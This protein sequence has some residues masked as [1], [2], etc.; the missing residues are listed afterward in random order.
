MKLDNTYY[1]KLYAGILGKIIGVYAGRPF[2]GWVNEHIVDQFGEINRYVNEQVNHPLIVSDDDITGTFMFTHALEDHEYR[3]D[4]SSQHLGQS[5]LDN[6]IEG[7][8]ILWWGGY[9]QSTEHTAWLNLRNGFEAPHSGSIE[10]NGK[11]VA[12]Q[13]GAQIF[14]DG[15]ALINPAMPDKAAQMA[16]EAAKVSHDGE[17]VHAAV[18]LAVMESQAFIETD[19]HALIDLGLS[20]I[21]KE[22][23]IAEVINA[24]RGWHEENPRDW[25][26]AFSQLKTHYG[27][28]KF[29]GTCHVIPNH[30]LIILSLLYGGESFHESMK[31]VNTLGWD[32]DCNAAN[33]GCL[34]GI[35][36]GLAALDDGFDWRTPVADRI[37]LPSANIQDHIFDAVQEA[38]KLY[39]IAHQLHHNER[40]PK[41]PR[42]HFTPKGSLQGFAIN[43][44][45][46]YNQNA[47]LSN[48]E[49]ALRLD[50]SHLVC[51]VPLQV[52]TATHTPL[53]SKVNESSYHI[54]GSP[55]LYPSQTIEASVSGATDYDHASVSFYVDAYDSQM[56]VERIFSEPF[57]LST[58]PQTHQWTL[59]KLDNVMIATVGLQISN[60]HS[61]NDAG[62]IKLHSLDWQ[63][64]PSQTIGIDSNPIHEIWESS[65]INTM[66]TCIKFDN[67]DIYRL[68]NND[69]SHPG[70][71]VY[72]SK[73]WHDYSLSIALK[74]QIK[75]AFG[76]IVRY[77]GL[78]RYYRV[79]LN[80][81]DQISLIR[82]EFGKDV[83][84]AIEPFQWQ[85]HERYH[86]DLSVN[87]NLFACSINGKQ[88][89]T[90]I[91]ETMPDTY[92][93]GG[94]G[95][96]NQLGPVHFTDMTVV[97]L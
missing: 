9:G 60:P 53:D 31:I 40:L 51:G 17:A 76:P 1:E 28:D 41:R 89:L 80:T 84:I 52:S 48:S 59:P 45:L 74:P 81:D 23:K 85:P 87:G 39:A 36:L 25:N 4:F 8:T 67:Q 66:D 47:R 15:W 13:I 7:K 11:T 95:F 43:P 34:N 21:P 92:Q 82:R 61:G 77:Q 14:I 46:N 49:Q 5:W 3:S 64:T 94:V 69:A 91:D 79:E 88:V 70:L 35:R 86:F 30:G 93:S 58:Q 90:S 16:T 27:Y 37:L 29:D 6:L 50:F 56:N 63:G 10:T 73:D 83:V 33:V 71:Y 42:F 78:E 68:V 12:E 32:T 62:Y 72:G 44:D 20:Y 57:T 75:Q 55:T 65:F 24:V 96:Y 97:A 22:S 2:E 54:V 38:D 26:W 19:L 18:L